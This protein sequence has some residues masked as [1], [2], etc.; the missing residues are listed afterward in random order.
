M[1]LFNAICDLVQ[2]Q[3]KRDEMLEIASAMYLSRTPASTMIIMSIIRSTS[4]CL[5]SLVLQFK[6]SL[7]SI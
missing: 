4:P 5:E 1:H 6:A 3:L 7:L 2:D